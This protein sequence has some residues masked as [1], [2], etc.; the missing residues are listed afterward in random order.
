MEICHQENLEGLLV[1]IDTEKAFDS[2]DHVFCYTAWIN[3]A[4]SN[5]ELCVINKKIQ[6]HLSFFMFGNFIPYY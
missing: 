3:L 4:I 2:L 1:T 5:Q 6:P